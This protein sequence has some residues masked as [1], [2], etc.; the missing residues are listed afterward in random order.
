M[1]WRTWGKRGEAQVGVRPS[2]GPEGPPEN[3]VSR[4]AAAAAA[5]P[6]AR[7]AP[8][9]GH[10]HL[11]ARSPHVG[12]GVG[13]R[14]VEAHVVLNN[15]LHHKALLQN[16]AV[17]DL[18]VRGV[19]GGVGV[20]L[21]GGVVFR[22]C[23][24]GWAGQRPMK[25]R[26]GAPREGGRRSVAP[27][28]GSAL[29]GPGP[30]RLP[31]SAWMSALTLSRLLWGSVQM[32]PASTSF[33]FCGGGI[34]RVE[35]GLEEGGAAGAGAVLGAAR[36]PRAAPAAPAPAAAAARAPGASLCSPRP[37]AAATA[38]PKPSSPPSPTAHLQA[39]DPLEAKGEELLGLELRAH[40]VLGRLQVAV[41][42]LAPQDC[43]LVSAGEG[44]GAP[45]GWARGRGRTRAA[46]GRTRP[47]ARPRSGRC[48]PAR[49]FP[50]FRPPSRP[51]ACFWMPSVMST[52][53]RMQL[54]HMLEGLGA[55][56]VP[57]RQQSL[58]TRGGAA[59]GAG[60]GTGRG[61]RTGGRR[62]RAA[63]RGP[64][65]GRPAPTAGAVD[66]RR[67][68]AAGRQ[69][70]AGGGQ[71]RRAAA[72][73]GGGRRRRRAAA[74]ARRP[75]GPGR[76][77][78]QPR[79]PPPPP[80]KTTPPKPP[81]AAA[82]AHTWPC[83]CCSW[84]TAWPSPAAGAWY[85]MAA[86][87]RG[88]P[89]AGVLG[90]WERFRPAPLAAG[91]GRAARDGRGGGRTRRAPGGC[92]KGR[93]VEPGKA[94]GAREPRGAERGAGRPSNSVN[95]AKAGCRAPRGPTLFIGKPPAPVQ[96]HPVP[97]PRRAP[98]PPC[99]LTRRRPRAP[100]GRRP[101]AA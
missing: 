4:R 29:L 51:P 16:G 23:A 95:V 47:R 21:G 71:R 81:P 35:G 72:A 9:A 34:A 87:A 11:H 79:R 10:T 1:C 96:H 57:Q 90:R 44:G 75:P 60:S 25:H 86:A 12:V 65:A 82:A 68:R 84:K 7:G 73:G 67:R 37:P 39:L 32:N 38:P 66:T 36:A 76:P 40:P 59:G 56:L 22:A 63:R 101:N 31:T 43:H 27:P 24:R 97:P 28:S 53:D 77:P 33:T 17:H 5:A 50:C 78:S 55:M 69:P 49:S 3:K 89:R 41:A 100:P 26:R 20:G 58:R 8:K 52:C 48:R 15:E 64:G 19:V 18:G 80:R 54:T 99:Q 83:V 14:A 42:V 62:R 98:I 93:K 74:A 30:P 46:R 92:G 88:A 94:Y 45:R 70:R 13:A 61:A 91:S 85:C 6:A 2:S